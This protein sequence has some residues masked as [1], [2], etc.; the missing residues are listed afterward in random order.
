MKTASC[1]V[2]DICMR[3]DGM[4][5]VIVSVLVIGFAGWV[6]WLFFGD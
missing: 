2:K 1:G 6:L 5:D 3:G 4:Y